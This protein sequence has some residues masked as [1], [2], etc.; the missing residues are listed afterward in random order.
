VC[1]RARVSCVPI[2][3][4]N[5]YCIF[6]LKANS[7]EMDGF[8]LPNWIRVFKEGVD[9]L[10]NNLWLYIPCGCGSTSK[11][12]HSRMIQRLADYILF[13]FTQT[14]SKQ[15]KLI[16]YLLNFSFLFLFILILYFFFSFSW[17]K[18]RFLLI[19]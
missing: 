17:K 8:N 13:W 14:I 10:M 15:I 1:A 11:S 5:R 3:G 6:Y 7:S 18:S 16:T 12:S 4:N 9:L 2:P 19:I